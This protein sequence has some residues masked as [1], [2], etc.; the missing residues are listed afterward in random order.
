MTL[1][2]IVGIARGST[3]LYSDIVHVPGNHN[4]FHQH[5]NHPG[6]ST[7]CPSLEGHVYQ[8][9]TSPVWF[10]GAQFKASSG[11]VIPSTVFMYRHHLRLQ[12][13]LGVELVCWVRRAWWRC[14]QS[15]HLLG[16]PPKHPMNPHSWL[17]SLSFL[18]PPSCFQLPAWVRPPGMGKRTQHDSPSSAGLGRE[19]RV[20]VS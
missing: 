20:L 13:P 17:V 19:R 8:A 10:L 4:P 7:A 18:L 11:A 2:D 1:P 5:L 12:G 15:A 16:N 6:H 14:N 3:V 9:N